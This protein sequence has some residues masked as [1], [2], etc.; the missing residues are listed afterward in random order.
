MEPL[1]RFPTETFEEH[2]AGLLTLRRPWPRLPREGGVWSFVGY[3][4]EGAALDSRQIP[5]FKKRHGFSL[6]AGSQHHAR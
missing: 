3:T 2:A 5:V 4:V 6:H 1:L